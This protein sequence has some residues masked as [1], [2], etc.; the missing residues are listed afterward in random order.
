MQPKASWATGEAGW[1]VLSGGMRLTRSTPSP[2]LIAVTN[3]LKSRTALAV[4]YRFDYD[5]QQ[6]K[7]SLA[8]HFG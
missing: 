7:E 3:C 6:G 1:F 2:P 4:S 5:D 8:S